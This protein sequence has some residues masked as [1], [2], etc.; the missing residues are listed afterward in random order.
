LK[1]HFQVTVNGETYIV[2]VEERNGPAIHLHPVEAPPAKTN[3]SPAQPSLAK[4]PPLPQSNYRVNS[5]IPGKV[6]EVRVKPGQKVTAGQVM[7]IIEAMK[8]ENEITAPVHGTVREVMV[9]AGATVTSGQL[10]VI[11]G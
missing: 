8:M 1:R 10:L 2:E 11:L 3:A 9:D 4:K 6:I 5:P 7:V